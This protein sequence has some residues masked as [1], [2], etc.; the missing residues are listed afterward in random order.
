[1]LEQGMSAASWD[2]NPCTHLLNCL[3]KAEHTT[4]LLLKAEAIPN[5]GMQG[6]VHPVAELHERNSDCLKRKRD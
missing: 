3:Q 5:L 1:M 6:G 4:V 2:E